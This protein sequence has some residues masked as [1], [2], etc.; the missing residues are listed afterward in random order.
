ME[1][2]GLWDG[3]KWDVHLLCHVSLVAFLSGWGRF[4]NPFLVSLILK[5]EPCGQS[6]RVLLLL[7]LDHAPL[8]KYIS[9]SFLFFFLM[10]SFTI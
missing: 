7:G 2:E 4:Y 3:G 6:C 10:V 9:T 1:K 8:F 5:P